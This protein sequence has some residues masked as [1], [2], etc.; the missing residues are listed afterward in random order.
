VPVADSA[1]VCSSGNHAAANPDRQQP[2]VRLSEIEDHPLWLFQRET[3]HGPASDRRL[4]LG[5][6]RE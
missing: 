5:W 2:I 6:N 4:P 3:D 1:A